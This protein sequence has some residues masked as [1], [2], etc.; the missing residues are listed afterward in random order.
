M[1][2]KTAGILLGILMLSAS[3]AG[4]GTNEATEAASESAQTEGEGTGEITEDGEKTEDVGADAQENS[5]ESEAAEENAEK[6]DEQESEDEDTENPEEAEEDEP[7]QKVAV[8]LPDEENWSVDAEALESNLEEDGYEPVVY[9]A[10]GDVS[11]QVSQIQELTEESV[12]AFIIAPVD[13]YGLPAVLSDV[14]EADIPVFSYDELIMDTNAVNYYT[15][16]GGRQVGRQIGEEIVKRQEL[17]TLREEKESRTIEFFMGSID[18]S[19][20]L[21]LYNGLM[22]VL[23]P[24]LDDGTLECPSGKIS[25]DDTGLLRWSTSLAESRMQ[26]IMEEFYEEG[27]APDIIC[28]G[29]D[30]AA[31]QIEEVLDQAGILP[32]SDEWPMITGAGCEAEAVK[33]IASGRMDFSIFMDPRE[34][35]ARC[36]D[37]VDAYLG[38][39]ED[40]D[41][42][43]PE[44]NDYESYDN[45]V[46]IVG[47]YLCESQVIDGDN[48]EILID[49]GF[50]TEDEV[51][52][53][54]TPTPTP[55]AEEPSPT[56]T[57]RPERRTTPV[58]SEDEPEITEAPSRK[59]EEPE[60]T[61]APAQEDEPETTEAPSRE[62]EEPETTKAPGS[63]SSSRASAAEKEEDA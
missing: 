56:P 8:L 18:D 50:Y 48:Y 14:R 47:A 40:P 27:E 30:K 34:M 4:C 60:A 36:E 24:Y 26:E 61:E 12:A 21:F 10:E 44:V 45:G 7:A 33:S 5:G 43:E 2:K 11:R 52:P 20:A 25:F 59:E 23:Q 63:A 13:P 55:E 62:E 54:M 29:F 9:Y 6:T 51:I 32:G 35:A 39:E 46:K 42:D 41:A 16:F 53:E 22:E 49:N 58:P 3:L 15:A 38:R 17:D 57:E 31:L 19:Q 1:K 37:M 28:T